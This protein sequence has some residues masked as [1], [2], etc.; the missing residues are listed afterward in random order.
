MQCNAIIILMIFKHFKPQFIGKCYISPMFV[1]FFSLDSMVCP[2]PLFKRE[3]LLFHLKR[4]N[5]QSQI[6]IMV[7][8]L[9]VIKVFFCLLVNTSTIWYKMQSSSVCMCMSKYLRLFRFILYI[10][11]TLYSAHRL[12]VIL[13]TFPVVCRQWVSK[14]SERVHILLLYILCKFI[15]FVLRTYYFFIKLFLWF[16]AFFIHGVFSSSSSSSSSASIVFYN[17]FRYIMFVFLSFFLS[18]FIFIF[19]LH[20]AVILHYKA[21]L[22]TI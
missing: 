18:L 6:I 14:V 10:Y 12:T 8:T 9:C 19:I 17:A 3:K 15:Y 13:L 21:M 4:S 11:N 1:V 7:V 16:Y 22:I 2:F 20:L 5:N